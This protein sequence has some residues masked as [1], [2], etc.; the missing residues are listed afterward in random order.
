MGSTSQL[1]GVVT[2]QNSF[3][4]C[5]SEPGEVRVCP[6][7]P[8]TRLEVSWDFLGLVSGSCGRGGSRRGKPGVREGW[9]DLGWKVSF[10]VFGVSL[11]SSP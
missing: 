9:K 4:R 10:E 2:L 1:L 8:G 3:C 7:A 11:N 5:P 6:Q